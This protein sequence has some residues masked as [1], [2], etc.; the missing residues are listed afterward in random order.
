M[1]VE[2]ENI[3]QKQSGEEAQLDMR[4]FPGDI[5]RAAREA[6]GL[7]TADVAAS[8]CLRQ[9]LIEELEANKFDP[10]VAVTFTRGYLR[11]Y[12]K[13]VEASEE[14]VLNAYHDLIDEKPQP[15]DMRSFSRKKTM[16]THDNR[17]MLITYVI[18][19][20]LIAS[21]V[22]FFWQQ[23]A[24]TN[25]LETTDM[26]ATSEQQTEQQMEPEAS[27]AM[28]SETQDAS[29]QAANAVPS[30][31]FIT[32]ASEQSA[33][34]TAQPF[35]DGANRGGESLALENE[36]SQPPQELTSESRD[37]TSPAAGE[38]QTP[39]PQQAGAEQAEEPLS[40]PLMNNETTAEATAENTPVTRTGSFLDAADPNAGELVLYFKGD[41]WVEVS[42][43]G[44]NENILAVGTKRKGYNMPLGGV[45][46][47][48][49]ILGAPTAVEVYY[50]GERVD[51]SALP[52]N[53]VVPFRVP[54]L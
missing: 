35:E 18:V 19:A 33:E 14:Y 34:Q 32:A 45:S 4:L 49:V 16:E 29:A 11:S 17:L 43:H 46:A 44:N 10:K 20:I 13:H 9:Q 50:Q 15:K 7:S 52:T 6:K 8:L 21:V 37:L 25:D 39:T 36:L 41:S 24:T 1:T 47:Y 51:L 54:E 23:S 30:D 38:E 53:R 40:E 31:A 22:L 48:N 26:P 12:A 42:E 28:P 3:Q 2:D 5:L 27:Q